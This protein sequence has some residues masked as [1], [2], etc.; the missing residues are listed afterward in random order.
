MPGTGNYCSRNVHKEKILM[1][2]LGAAAKI[3][4]CLSVAAWFSSSAH[5]EPK[6][7]VDYSHG[8]PT[9]YSVSQKNQNAY[10]YRPKKNSCDDEQ[11]NS[12]VPNISFGGKWNRT[13]L[14]VIGGFNQGRDAKGVC[15]FSI[16]GTGAFNHLFVYEGKKQVAKVPVPGMFTIDEI[17]ELDGSDQYL[18]L[19]GGLT[20]MGGTEMWASL[21]NTSTG[22]LKEIK[23]FR[24]VYHDDCSGS[25]TE[26]VHAVKIFYDP[27]VSSFSSQGSVRACQE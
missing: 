2:K 18:I 27:V 17:P 11:L 25:S 19:S 4:A 1:K 3:L 13:L 21:Y 14:L 7:L 24:E 5:A 22:K 6:L 26:G 16:P 8:G 9:K 12:R 20:R 23:K 15:T 10:E